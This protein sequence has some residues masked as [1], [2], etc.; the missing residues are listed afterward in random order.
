MPDKPR[1]SSTDVPDKAGAPKKKQKWS[2]K[3]KKARKDSLAKGDGGYSSPKR[4][5]RKSD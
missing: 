4:N 5:N 1:V 3:R 2:A